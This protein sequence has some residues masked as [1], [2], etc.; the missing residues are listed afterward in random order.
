MARF[1]II[2]KNR[3]Y[4][5]AEFDSGCP[6]KLLIDE[7]SKTLDVGQ[8]DLDLD[9]ISVRSKYGT[10]LKYKL[11]HDAV[12]QKNAGITS[13][14]HD[15]FNENLVDQCKKLG[16]KWDSEEK[17]WIFSALVSD[18]VEALDEKYNSPKI[19]VEL[20]A[21]GEVCAHI[22]PLYIAG[23]KIAQAYGRDSGARQSD[24]I[25]VIAGGFTSGGS[26]KNWYTV[27]SEGTVIRLEL[28]EKTIDDI[29]NDDWEVIRL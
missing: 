28:P 12:A 27:A 17:A 4:F 13:L 1:K 29:N 11:R 3:K 26:A 2:K 20:R 8:H 18:E 7:N 23:Y 5:A 22:S 16:G 21:I 6:F 10:D 25:S 19:A 24:N 14:T 9:D 15:H